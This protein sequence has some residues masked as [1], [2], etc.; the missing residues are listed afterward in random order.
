MHQYL[1]H[2]C[3]GFLSIAAPALL[4]AAWLFLMLWMTV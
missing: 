1:K 3:V 2:L 4:F